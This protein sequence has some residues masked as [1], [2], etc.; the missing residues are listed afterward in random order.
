[1]Y[2]FY[3]SDFMLKISGGFQKVFFVII[4]LLPILFVPSSVISLEPLKVF[5]VLLSGT[6]F[7]G[8]LL[9]RKI[10]SDTLKVTYDPLVLSCLG[11]ILSAVLA[12]IFSDNTAVSLFGRQISFFSLMGLVSLFAFAY[13]VY[14]SLRDAQ[15]KT[16]FFLWVYSSSILVCVVHL[17]FI[18]I[19]AIPSLG[20]FYAGTINTIGSWS[21]MGFFALF[22]VLTSVIVL[23]FL[24]NIPLYKMMGLAGLISGTLLLLI[25][26]YPVLLFLTA[27]YSG[28]VIGVDV[29]LESKVDQEKEKSSAI[30]LSLLVLSVVFIF[31]GGIITPVVNSFLNLES[32]EARPSIA[33]TYEVT[34]SVLRNSPVFGQGL[35][36]FDV[37]WLK[38]QPQGNLQSQFWDTDFRSGYSAVTS[39]GVTQGI[40]GMV[41]WSIFIILIVYYAYRLMIIKTSIRSELFMN[42]YSVFGV[43]F[44]L[45][46]R[47]V[48]N[49]SIVLT[50][51]LFVFLG[52]FFSC[53]R[54]AGLLKVKKVSL[55]DHK[56]FV[57]L[58]YTGILILSLIS[59]LYIAYIQVSQ[60]ASRV[61]FDE[62]VKEFYET[63]NLNELQRKI[64]QS[65]SIFNSDVY[66]RLAIE[67]NIIAMNQAVQDSSLSQ[68]QATAQVSAYL[69]QA[70]SNAQQIMY[71]DSRSYRN[72]LSLI[73][74]Y[75]NLVV[76][77]VEGAEQETRL[78]IDNAFNF[79]PEN[80]RLFLEKARLSVIDQDGDGAL[81][82][83]EKA[84]SVNPGHVDSLVLRAQI[85]N[86][87]GD[88][89][90][91]IESLRLALQ[92]DPRNQDVYLQL[93][94]VYY[95][96]GEFSSA[97]NVFQRLVLGAPNLLD[98]WYLFGIS[99]Y[100]NGQVNDA[101][102][103]FKDLKEQ[104]PEDPEI[105]KILSRMESGE[106]LSGAAV[107]P[108]FEDEEVLS[109]END[110]QEE[111]EE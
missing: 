12:T 80:P 75:K 5:I 17:L 101:I 43:L 104:V 103:I 58:I 7:L 26:G 78:I 77:G 90:G 41:A 99:L 10:S 65:R 35:D 82:E 63:N 79:T 24:G 92:S 38:N 67:A 62:A 110:L 45:G 47:I 105:A 60:Y 51:F 11:I 23:R 50:L 85:L 87:Q 76:L 56:P 71:F 40:V 9:A 97:S 96:Q 46:V 68:D 31:F 15:D 6:V 91:A 53:L 73:G 109:L 84:L 94:M 34:E 37:A 72:Y 32:Q 39:V 74:L 107:A 55:K 54:A 19:P 28:L 98:G 102:E 2:E 18:F 64:N 81:V 42:V 27:L 106:S 49:P 14:L 1:V 20:F 93:G 36:R 86:E 57:S 30:P 48:Y 100:R 70:Q 44:F 13:A 69:E 4:G 88:S 108:S 95:N 59:V 29:F 83:I 111:S 52:L 8:V 33:G 61:F 16:Q 3:L 21:E 89:D 22:T 25:V 66:G